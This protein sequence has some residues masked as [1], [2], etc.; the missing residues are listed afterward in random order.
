MSEIKRFE[1]TQIAGEQ[2]AEFNK[3]YDVYNRN[4]YGSEL[5]S[6][7]NKADNYNKTEVINKGYQKMEVTVTYKNNMSGFDSLN[8]NEYIIFKKNEEYKV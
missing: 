7:V 8:N 3:Q 2:I 6:L 5:L 4:L 1:E